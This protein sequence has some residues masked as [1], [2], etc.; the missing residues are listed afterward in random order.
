MRKIF[1]L[2]LIITTIFF[3][4]AC[5]EPGEQA[6]NQGVK[7][8]N[9]GETEQ[10]RASFLQALE[11]NPHLAEAYLNLGRIDIKLADYTSARR[12]TLKALNLLQEHK[13]TIRSG[14]T[15][16]KQAALACNNMASIAFQ[17]AMLINEGK[18]GDITKDDGV[19]DGA[20]TTDFAQTEPGRSGSHKSSA[21]AEALIN[22]AVQWLEQALELDPTNET[23]L[24]NHRFIQKW[25]E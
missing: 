18:G 24:K 15:W 2:T 6:Y 10:A 7:S 1:S 22:E 5:S 20:G 16:T 11:E 4:A 14:S 21:A 19:D 17:Q 25:R 9:G 13:T 8:L 12:N 3:L 23:V